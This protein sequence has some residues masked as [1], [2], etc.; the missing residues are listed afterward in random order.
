MRTSPRP[1]AASFRAPRK[2]ERRSPPASVANR[3]RTMKDGGMRPRQSCARTSSPCSTSAP[4]PIST[5]SAS[6]GSRG[7]DQFVRHTRPRD[8]RRLCISGAGR[9]HGRRQSG[10]QRQGLHRSDDFVGAADQPQ[11]TR[12]DRQ[13]AARS[14][15]LP[16]RRRPY[17]NSQQRRRHRHT[18][19]AALD[20][21]SR[22]SFRTGRKGFCRLRAHDPAVR[23]QGA[24]GAAGSRTRTRIRNTEASRPARERN[25]C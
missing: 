9:R 8:N 18:R 5:A 11:S 14:Q 13:S 24:R 1:R 20:R 2:L 10:T 21:L 25:C 3:S 17:T 19:A 7:R 6:I 23:S 16:E 22:R 12:R 15:L 4:T